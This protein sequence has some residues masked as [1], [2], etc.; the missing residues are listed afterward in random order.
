MKKQRMTIEELRELNPTP[1]NPVR[2]ECDNGHWVSDLKIID[3]IAV[4]KD[5]LL[6][7]NGSGREIDVYSSLLQH[8]PSLKPEPKIET[9]YECLDPT[10]ASE[11]VF[12]DGRYPIFEHKTASKQRDVK[13]LTRKTGRTLK[14]N[15]DT[16]E[17]ES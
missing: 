16:W 4:G 12:S 2:L 17:I 9:L 14:L 5:Q 6:V 3:V 11:F 7:I 1:E 13:Q 8:Y 15:M 10:G